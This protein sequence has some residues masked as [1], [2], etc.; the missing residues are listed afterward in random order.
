MTDVVDTLPTA[1][2]ST[3]KPGSHLFGRG[4]LYVVIWSLQLI[5]GIVV[6]PILA[7]ALPPVQFGAL[8]SAIAL[9]QVLSVVTLL[10]IDKAIVLERAEN[11]DD[12]A[13]RG[14]V[15]V[16]IAVAL[17]IT[18]AFGVTAPLW[19]AALGFG[20]FPDLVLAVIL[21]TGP[22][23]AVQVMLSL[24]LTEDRLRPFAVVSAISAVGGQVVG[25]V[26]L[27]TVR[28]DATTYAWGG[29]ASQ[30]VAMLIGVAVTRPRIRGLFNWRVTQRAIRLGL[31]LVL[32]GLG[33]FLLNAGDRI[34]IQSTL[35]QAAVARYQVAYVVGSVVILLLTFTSSAWT[36]RFAGLRTRTERWALAALS[37]DELYRLLMPM[38]L[39]ATLAAPIALRLVAPAS[40][41]PESLTLVV[42]L[43]ALSAYPVAASGATGQ[44]LITE[45]RGGAV[46]VMTAVAALVNIGLNL[47]LVPA[48]GITGAAIATL[49]SFALLAFLQSRTL[50]TEPKLHGPSSRLVLAI[51]ASTAIAGASALLPQ[52]V[53]W[54]VTCLAAAVCCVPWFVLAL[55]RARRGPRE[56][57]AM[58]SGRRPKGKHSL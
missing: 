40:Y 36:P 51:L 24:L 48:I 21:W 27:F 26:L 15:T 23:A 14:L 10:G 52:T 2:E 37:R 33:Y 29:V 39:G 30:F 9:Y 46:G 20:Q 44:L 22:A 4:M 13:A 41:H 16:A 57:R 12:R 1:T 42:F 43:V 54:N 55:Q 35:G 53:P 25:L 38:T 28:D 18:L 8:A 3:P 56:S 5:A 34:V 11:A 50:P 19:R 45:R 58:L 47:L 17:L 6:S 31:P 49:V 7:H 32:A